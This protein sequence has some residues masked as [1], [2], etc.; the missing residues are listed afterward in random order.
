MDSLPAFADSRFQWVLPYQGDEELFEK[1][2]AAPGSLIPFFLVAAEDETWSESHP[3]FIELVL[4][5][6]TQ[7]S[8]SGKLDPD[9]SQKLLKAYHAHRAILSALLP[10]PITLKIGEL[11]LPINPLIAS[12]MSSYLADRILAEPNEK[13][14]LITNIEQEQAELLLKYIEQGFL[15]DL[16]RYHKVE[17]EKLLQAAEAWGVASLAKECQVV[18]ARYVDTDSSDGALLQ[19]LKE[20]R[21][22]IAEETVRRINKNEKGII[23]SLL[24]DEGIS[25]EPLELIERVIERTI[26]LAPAIVELKAGGQI[27]DDP[28]FWDLLSDLPRLRSLDLTGSD[29]VHAL[30]LQLPD[31]IKTLNLSRCSWLDDNKFATICQKMPFLEKLSLAQNTQLTSKVWPHL[32]HFNQLKALDLSGLR[33]ITEQDKKIIRSMLPGCLVNSL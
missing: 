30:L 16:F 11:A 8:L 20:K 6:I 31:R 9:L 22:L 33:Q 25:A 24:D 15:H 28:R 5:S 32:R 18:M 4:L 1:L 2:R 17:L 7:A 26:R 10:R 14:L 13:N 27:P 23:L 3:R 21:F 29:A 19:A 12:M